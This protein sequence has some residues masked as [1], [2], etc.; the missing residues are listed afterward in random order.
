VFVSFTSFLSLYKKKC[1]SVKA[2]WT[3]RRWMLF[4]ETTSIS[5]EGTQPALSR[6][7]PAWKTHLGPQIDTDPE[8]GFNSSTAPEGRWNITGHVQEG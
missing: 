4:F 3:K 6:V 1:G 5:R 7:T 8:D 2:S